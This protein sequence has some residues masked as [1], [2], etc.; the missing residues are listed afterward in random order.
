[1]KSYETTEKD[2]QTLELGLVSNFPS[3][4]SM[5]YFAQAFCF[6]PGILLGYLIM[7]LASLLFAVDLFEYMGW[8]IILSFCIVREAVAAIAP[9]VFNV[10]ARRMRRDTL[11]VIAAYLL[12]MVVPMRVLVRGPVKGFWNSL[13]LILLTVASIYL[14]CILFGSPELRKAVLP[15]RSETRSL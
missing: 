12:G 9:K 15:A 10:A 7:Y 2:S 4:S 6:L 14:P 3:R 8:I 11:V 1:M 5:G 13:F